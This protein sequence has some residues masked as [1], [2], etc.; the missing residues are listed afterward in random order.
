[1]V[2]RNV[3]ARFFKS[4]IMT[5]NEK[6]VEIVNKY[7]LVENTQ[8]KMGGNLMF[9]NE[10]KICAIIA[11]D[12]IIDLDYFSEEGREYWLKV[13]KEVEKLPA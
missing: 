6:A 9:K 10:A 12:E 4:Q 13:K 2:T 3:L 11:I 5:P 1:M 8:S 7:L